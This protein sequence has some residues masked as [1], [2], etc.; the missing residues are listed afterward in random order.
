MTSIYNGAERGKAAY[1][2]I[3]DNLNASSLSNVKS[4]PQQ[5]TRTDQSKNVESATNVKPENNMDDLEDELDFLLSLKE[6]V[7][8]TVIGIIPP[9]SLSTSSNG[10]ILKKIF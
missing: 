5:N 10:K 4:E 1:N 8:S 6:P 2:T 7:Q 3:L 9:M